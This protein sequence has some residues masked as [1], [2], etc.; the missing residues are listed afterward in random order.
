MNRY[1]VIPV[2]ELKEVDP[3]WE[4]R[5]KNVDATEAI[6]HVETYDTLVS[7]RN[8]G[9][10]PLSEDT[11]EGENYPVYQG[12]ELEELLNSPEWIPDQE[13]GR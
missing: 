4:T 5:R 7:E 2:S 3:D 9:I 1:Y 10:M 11:A 6:I 13:G 8:K 12:K